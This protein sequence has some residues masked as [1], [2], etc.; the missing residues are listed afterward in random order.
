MDDVVRMLFAGPAATAAVAK[1]VLNRAGFAVSTLHAFGESLETT[2]LEVL[3][4]MTDPELDP[5]RWRRSVVAIADALMALFAYE[6]LA[7]AGS[8]AP[9]GRSQPGARRTG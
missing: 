3:D 1:R 2:Y 5:A 8:P 6:L 7:L 4:V 9:H